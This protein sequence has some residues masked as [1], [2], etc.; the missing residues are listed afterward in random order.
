MVDACSREVFSGARTW[1][2]IFDFTIDSI[3]YVTGI[4]NGS[5]APIETI[6]LP[7][8]QSALRCKKESYALRR[9]E[10]P[11]FMC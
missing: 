2:I 5:H 11:S 6:H 3:D 9:I 1:I 10:G 8:V 7:V 4:G